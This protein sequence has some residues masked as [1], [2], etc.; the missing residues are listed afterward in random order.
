MLFGLSTLC[1]VSPTFGLEN[2]STQIK[3]SI[4][5]QK[6]Q[7]TDSTSAT[8]LKKRKFS[9]NKPDARALIESLGALGL[10]ITVPWLAY[11][12]LVV[13]PELILENKNIN[14][15]MYQQRSSVKQL[16]CRH[17]PIS[18]YK[19]QLNKVLGRP[20]N[21]KH[22]TID[23]KVE[24]W[25]DIMRLYPSEPPEDTT[26]LRSV[27]EKLPNYEKAKIDVT[28][29]ENRQIRNRERDFLKELCDNIFANSATSEQKKQI[30]KITEEMGFWQRTNANFIEWNKN[31]YHLNFCNFNQK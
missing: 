12:K 27:M 20:E 24:I 7:N 21:K 15:R 17:V 5:T 28:P 18:E 26:E 3:N 4:V 13:E 11:E 22:Q 6:E 2:N 30:L 9:F 25:V 29:L 14:I 10:I 8:T 1:A 19:D 16:C 31:H 23:Y